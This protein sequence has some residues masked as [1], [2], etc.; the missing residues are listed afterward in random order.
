M[1]RSVNRPINNDKPFGPAE[2]GTD[3]SALFEQWY[4]A[5]VEADPNN[6][7]VMTLATAFDN[8]PSA[9]MVL[10]KEHGP[11]GFVFYTNYE[12]RKAREL[13]ANP[14]AALVFW[15]QALEKQIRIEG[16]IE[17]I[18][19]DASDAYFSTRPRDSQLGAWASAQSSEIDAPVTLDAAKKKFGDAPIPR[20]CNWGGLRLIPERFEFW[21]GRNSRLHDRI[22]F[23]RIGSRWTIS[24]LAP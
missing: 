8:R 19:S 4:A 5:A 9:R 10:F 13:E 16:R 2:A 14:H 23:E 11:D 12:S 17:K 24:R 15:F 18:S 7:A 6:A 20:P 3:P 21:Q 22:C 1:L